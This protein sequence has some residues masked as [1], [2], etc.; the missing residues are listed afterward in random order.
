[1]TKYTT[2]DAAEKMNAM[3]TNYKE[4]AAQKYLSMVH[5]HAELLVARL[6][7]VMAVA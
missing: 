1:M 2:K 3:V 7:N 6:T 4:H 5:H